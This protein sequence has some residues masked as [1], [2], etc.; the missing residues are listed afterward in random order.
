MA[1]DLESEELKGLA[2][3]IGSHMDSMRANLQQVDG[4]VPQVVRSRAALQSLLFRHLDQEQYEQ[5]VLG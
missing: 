3:Q 1:Q 2:R 4:V 5:A